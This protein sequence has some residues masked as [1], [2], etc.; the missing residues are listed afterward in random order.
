[1][2]E[3]KGQKR[4][5]WELAALAK[6]KKGGRVGAR[7]VKYVAANKVKL[8]F[9][10]QTTG[11]KWTVQGM[12]VGPQVIELNTAQA[13][14][15]RSGKDAWTIS[16]IAHEA[17]HYEQGLT[18]AL[19]VYG[20]LEAWQLQMKVLRELGAPPTHPSLLAIEKLKLS[21][22]EAV[23]KEAAR[24]MKEYHSGYRIDLLPLNPV[25]LASV[26]GSL[27]KLVKAQASPRPKAA[28]K[29]KRP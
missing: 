14:G 16:L 7:A 19:S 3:F 15:V 18:T 9:A 27:S 2:K 17:K 23:L 13:L 10:K 29:T 1:M 22:D 25:G 24:L 4:E 28:K 11:A 26:M 8:G 21:H 20:E 5:A 6:L 12:L